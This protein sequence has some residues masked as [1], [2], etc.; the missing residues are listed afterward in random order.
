MP[1]AAAAHRG[2]RGA[3][4]RDRKTESWPSAEF[5]RVL[6]YNPL[7]RIRQEPGRVVLRAENPAV[8]PLEYLPEEVEIHAMPKLSASFAL[9][10]PDHPAFAET[11]PDAKP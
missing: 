1:D 11:A 2:L 3:Q 5:S 10:Y 9:V 7:K 8:P 4:G 6:A